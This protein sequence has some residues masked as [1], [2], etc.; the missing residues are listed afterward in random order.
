[1]GVLEDQTA[2]FFRERLGKLGIAREVPIEEVRR[3]APGLRNWRAAF[4]TA[5][6]HIAVAGDSGPPIAEGSHKGTH[7]LWPTRQSYRASFLMWG[8][9][10]RQGRLGEISMLEIAPTLAEILQVRPAREPASNHS[11]RV[12]ESEIIGG[13]WNTPCSSPASRFAAKNRDLVELPYD[14]SL[15]GTVFQASRED[16]DKA[17]VAALAAAPVMRGMTLDE[18][19]TLLT[20]GLP[21]TV[22][23][24][25]GY[26]FGRQL[27]DGK[28]HQRGASGSRSGGHDAAILIRR[29]APAAWRGRANGRRAGGPGPLGHDRARTSGCHRRDHALQLPIEPGDAQDRAGARR[30]QR[31]DSQASFG[32][33]HQR[34]QDG[35]HLSGLRAARRCAQRDHGAGRRCRRSIGLR[36]EDRHG[37]VSPAA[38]TWGCASGIWRG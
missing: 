29:S 4:D 32:D 36:Q 38:W 12:S 8:H 18:R 24:A 15:V 33:A 31:R 10:V 11:G 14:G 9:G 21:E 30:G 3:A 6:G 37:H 19:S 34:D 5:P 35:G 20:K 2:Q 22:G 28:A 26:G 13:V 17:I 27:R 23:T 25:R 1:M 7:G 16:V